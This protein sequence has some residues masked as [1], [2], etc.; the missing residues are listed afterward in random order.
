MLLAMGAECMLKAL[1][2]KYGGILAKEGKFDPIPDAHTHELD[3]LAKAVSLKGDI[4]FSK[5]E[6]ALLKLASIWI[7]SGRYPI[8]KRSADNPARQKAWIGDPVAELKT[9]IQKLDSELCIRMNFAP[10]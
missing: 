2:L 1:W 4:E 5:R 6:Y 3:R 7:V 8:P 10:E 9:L